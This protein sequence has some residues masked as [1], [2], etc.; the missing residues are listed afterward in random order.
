MTSGF[1]QMERHEELLHKCVAF[2]IDKQVLNKKL[3]L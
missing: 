1:L 3:A 2:S